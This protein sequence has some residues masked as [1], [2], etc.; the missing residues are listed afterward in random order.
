MGPEVKD[1]LTY[2]GLFGDVLIIG[3]YLLM[4]CH[5]LGAQSATFLLANIMGSIFVISSLFSEWSATLCF[6][7][8]SWLSI[9]LYGFL[10]H[11]VFAKAGTGFF[12]E[13]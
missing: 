3:S 11:V 10:R 2:L 7:Q 13:G 8:V 1:A 5:K 12:L 9:S 6:I 4:Q